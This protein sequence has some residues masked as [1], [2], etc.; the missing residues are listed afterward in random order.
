MTF[1]KNKHREQGHLY[2]T[3]QWRETRKFILNNNP[4]CAICLEMGIDTKATEIDHILPVRLGA[5]FFDTN[6]LQG[7]CKK[8]HAK[9]SGSERVIK[10]KYKKIIR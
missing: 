5:D 8:C 9:K 1:D 3:T 2:N 6:N 10:P 7:L 4:F